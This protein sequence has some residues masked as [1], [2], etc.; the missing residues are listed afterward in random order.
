MGCVVNLVLFAA[1]KEFCK[2][3]KNNGKVT[4]MI[5]VAPFFDSRC[6][7]LSWRNID[8]HNI[9]VCMSVC[10][11]VCVCVCVCVYV[12]LVRRL[13]TLLL[14]TVRLRSST[15]CCLACLSM[16]QTWYID[17]LIIIFIIAITSDC[18]SLKDKTM[19]KLAAS[20]FTHQRHFLYSE[21][22][23]S[24]D[25][26]WCVNAIGGDDVTCSEQNVPSCPAY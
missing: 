26:L 24:R 20:V 4:A 1:V 18:Q 14:C 3:I 2:S 11:S 10:L 21:R 17:H 8:M 12:R 6:R 16:N 23:V 19:R 5:R 13:Y 25:E 15:Y 7:T 9:C 22:N